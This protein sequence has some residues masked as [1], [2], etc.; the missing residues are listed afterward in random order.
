MEASPWVEAE[1]LYQV[2]Q[3]MRTTSTVCN[4][5]AIPA[6]VDAFARAGVPGPRASTCAADAVG[7]RCRV[8]YA[9]YDRI[10]AAKLSLIKATIAIAAESWR[11]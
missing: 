8:G 4:R 1:A 2:A 9:L 5:G 10:R 7:R 6:G 11:A 3:S